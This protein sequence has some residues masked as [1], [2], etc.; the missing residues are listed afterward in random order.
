MV[1]QLPGII[2]TLNLMLCKPWD[3]CIV[4]CMNR[5][6]HGALGNGLG[7]IEGRFGS[8]CTLADTGSTLLR[9]GCFRGMLG[10][11]NR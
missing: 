11:F 2:P 7:N 3:A 1:T 4:Q 8:D 6:G 10:K 9:F 5:T